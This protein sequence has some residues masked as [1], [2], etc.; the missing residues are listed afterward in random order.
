MTDQYLP[1]IFKE[2]ED[3]AEKNDKAKAQ[4]AIFTV[5]K[6]IDSTEKT[7]TKSP[8]PF[9]FVKVEIQDS[10]EMKCDGVKMSSFETDVD[11]NALIKPMVERIEMGK[12]VCLTC[13]KQFPTK[14]SVERHAEVHLGLSQ[15]CIV[16]DKIFNTRNTL[17][18]HYTKRH[19]GEL[20]S[21]RSMK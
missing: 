9:N 2:K 12:Y 3:E 10:S 21:P 8:P 11:I 14:Q 6:S 4:K 20:A 17:A 5:K 7:L 19:G 15:H 16:C 13:R 1:N 18:T